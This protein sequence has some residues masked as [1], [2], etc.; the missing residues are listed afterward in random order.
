MKILSFL[1]AGRDHL[2]HPCAVDPFRLSTCSVPPAAIKGRELEIE[3]E[4]M[5][6]WC[7]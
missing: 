7:F 2:G 1:F 4:H 3:S 5:V 6:T